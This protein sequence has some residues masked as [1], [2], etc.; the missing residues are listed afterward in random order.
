MGR[1]AGVSERDTRTASIVGDAKT[2][3]TENAQSSGAC[4]R[5]QPLLLGYAVGQAG[6]GIAGC[7]ENNAARANLCRFQHHGLCGLAWHR[8]RDTI[9]NL[10]QS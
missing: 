9:R 8:D 6:F 1:G 5:G 2:V 7:I 4:N 10:G 3:R